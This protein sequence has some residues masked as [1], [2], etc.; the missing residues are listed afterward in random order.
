MSKRFWLATI[1][2]SIA[3]GSTGT[4]GIQQLI[5]RSNNKES[6][7]VYYFD[8]KRE[9]GFKYIMP[10]QYV[11]AASESE[12]YLDLKN[13]LTD[14]IDS[15]KKTGDINRASVYLRDFDHSEWMSVFP[16]ERFHPGS[17]LK[18]GALINILQQADRDTSLLKK[19]L[20]FHPNHEKIPSQSYCKKSIIEG[21]S[22]SIE[23]LL[24]YMIAN[25]DNYATSV[26]HQVMNYNDYL[27]I[28]STLHI[29]VPDGANPNYAVRANEISNLLKVLYNG[30]FL[31]PK[32]SEK[33]IEIMMKCDFNSGMQAGL[34]PQIKI[35][36]KFGEYGT[37]DGLHE[38]H[39]MGIIYLGVKPYLLTIM[40]EGKNIKTLA[41]TIAKLTE[42]SRK[43]LS[44]H[45][46]HQCLQNQGGE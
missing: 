17:I 31:S 40:T 7:N 32:M 46:R 29:P 13:Q 39:E 5:N 20:E 41:P 33:A 45:P 37:K 12:K 27:R 16:N 34:S 24:E 18:L 28:F 14:C 11:E 2:L 9:E 21:R 10:L 1:V 19:K 35:A 4:L 23:Q 42:N 15:L 38:L 25:S 3:A 8:F 43:Y 44:F 30:T 36:H 6:D 26:L 22:Y